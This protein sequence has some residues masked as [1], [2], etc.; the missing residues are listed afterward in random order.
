VK[1]EEIQ[2]SGS[3][4]KHKRKSFQTTQTY[5]QL[6]NE[7]EAYIS[8]LE[9]N[10][11][12]ERSDDEVQELNPEQLYFSLRNQEREENN[13]TIL[14]YLMVFLEIACSSKKVEEDM[15][16]PFEQF[17]SFVL[18]NIHL[19]KEV[20]VIQAVIRYGQGNNELKKNWNEYYWRLKISRIYHQSLE[21]IKDRNNKSI[22][23]CFNCFVVLMDLCQ[24]WFDIHYKNDCPIR[25]SDILTF[26]ICKAILKIL[27]QKKNEQQE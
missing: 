21:M 4:Q 7:A 18:F 26:K 16:N 10:G 5:L 14:Q 2:M 9:N 1:T 24:F 12:P 15:V 17:R 20:D 13:K 19:L 3:Y 6:I 23:D 22:M 27:E 11:I 8:F 25:H